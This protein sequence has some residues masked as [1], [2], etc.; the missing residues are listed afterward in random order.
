[1]TQTIATSHSAEQRERLEPMLRAVP[2]EVKR[3]EPMARH[4]SLKVGGPAEMMVF[5]RYPE[6]LCETSI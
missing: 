1:M 2:V 5:P 4:T 3:A 6:D